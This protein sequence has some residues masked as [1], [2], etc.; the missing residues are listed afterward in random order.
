MSR[1]CCRDI[2]IYPYLSRAEYTSNHCGLVFHFSVAS[3]RASGRIWFR[4]PPRTLE[5]ASV[6]RING[7]TIVAG[8]CLRTPP[9]APVTPFSSCSS[10]ATCTML[11]AARPR[12]WGKYNVGNTLE[13]RNANGGGQQLLFLHK[14][15]NQWLSFHLSIIIIVLFRVS[16]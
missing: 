2:Y 4:T 3:R 7:W 6:A 1:K 11:V 5:V 8:T 14:L 9:T 16:L 13:T 12:P 10:L 15:P